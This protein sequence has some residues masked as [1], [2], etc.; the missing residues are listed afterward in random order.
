MLPAARRAVTK[1]AYLKAAMR[2]TLISD[3]SREG[4]ECRV[5]RT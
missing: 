1:A 3:P 4:G 5:I 2:S